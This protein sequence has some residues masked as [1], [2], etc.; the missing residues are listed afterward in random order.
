MQVILHGK[1]RD[2]YVKT[3][4]SANCFRGSLCNIPW[5]RHQM[6]TFSV[7]LAICAGNSLVPGEFPAQRPVTRSF[8]VFFDLHPN[9]QL[10][11]Q[12]WGWW[13][14][15]PSVHYDVTIMTCIQRTLLIILWW[16]NAL[17]FFFWKTSVILL[18]PEC[19]LITSIPS[20]LENMDQAPIPSM[21]FDWILN[22]TKIT[23]FYIPHKLCII[24]AQIDE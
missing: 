15:M 24:E 21:I 16:T 8:D 13:F 4:F 11:K 20:S 18:R 3:F 22:L 5:W 1:V 23:R 12:W 9:K 2:I 7:L 17:L 10:S 14:E 6:E 19:I